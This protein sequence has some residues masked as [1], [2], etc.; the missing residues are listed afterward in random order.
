MPRRLKRSAPS[1]IVVV[2]A[3][4]WLAI[5]P[6]GSAPAPAF[7]GPDENAVLEWNLNAV[8]ALS[9]ATTQPL[10][11]LP[12]I[13]FLGAGETPPVAA[14]QL[15]IVQGAVYDAV[16]AIDRGHEPYL[17][18]LPPASAKAS[19]AAAVAT[20]AHHV[21][22]GLVNPP[23]GQLVLS[24]TTRTWLDEKYSASLAGIPEGTR[25]ERRTN[26]AG[27][28]AGAA[29][30]REMLSVRANDGRFGTF[31]FTPGTAPGQWRPTATPPVNDPF[32]W[33]AKVEPFLIDSP[34][35][36]RTKGPKALGSRAYA[37]EYD[38]VKNYGGNGTTTPTLRTPEQAALA[39]FY[40]VN[41]VELFNRTFREIASDE[42][43]SLVEEARLFAMLNMVV[44]D[45]VISC[46]DD[47]AFWNFWRPITA[48]MLGDTD[49]NPRTVQDGAWTSLLPA[50]P[51][52]EHPSGYNCVTSGFM[53]AAKVFFGGN[54]M[55]FSV[56]RIAPGAPNVTRDYERFTDVVEDTIDARVY[57]GI[58]FRAGD[59]QA[60]EIGKNVARWLDRHTDYFQPVHGP[61]HCG[62]ERGDREDEV[63]KDD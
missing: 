36:F 2:A 26:F 62:G 5:A 7:A 50:P 37:R 33:V 60:A 17:A 10:P 3:F 49:G 61:V 43:L 16:N 23:T 59:K 40:T 24:Q 1:A 57:Q 19:K 34:T 31:L 11:P 42:G 46:W 58:H 29:A 35:Q 63:E 41:P 54:S 45:S 38:E 25:R 28:A 39:G 51:Y 32:A 53:H 13:E 47:K 4:V 14:T 12:P 56:E 44:A 20:A 9:N 55:A 15:A 21:L 48:I 30:A 52:P 27:I 6:L 22:V 18:G 8:S